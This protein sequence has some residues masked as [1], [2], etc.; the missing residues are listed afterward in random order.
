MR[1]VKRY[2]DIIEE[3]EQFIQVCNSNS[4]VGARGSSTMGTLKCM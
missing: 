1:D 2:K 3:Q 4:D